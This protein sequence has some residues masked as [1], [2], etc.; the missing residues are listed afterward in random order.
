[1]T[2]LIYGM[3]ESCPTSLMPKG[4]VLHLAETGDSSDPHPGIDLSGE[5]RSRM[6]RLQWRWGSNGG[7]YPPES[8]K[9]AFNR[10]VARCGSCAANTPDNHIWVAGNEPNHSQEGLHFPQYTAKCYEAIRTSIKAQPGHGNDIIL[11]PAIAPWNIEIGV[12]WIEYFV[13]A[14]SLCDEIDGFAIHTY[15]RGPDPMSIIADTYMNPPYDHLHNGFQT[16]RDWM[17][18]IP[19]RYKNTPVYITET[20]QNEPWLNENNGWVQMAYAEINAWNQSSK[21]PIR[22]LLLY[23][24]PRFDAYFIDS[25]NGVHAD[26]LAA[27]AHQYQVGDPDPDPG[28]TMPSGNLLLNGSMEQGFRLITNEWNVPQ[29]SINVAHNWFPWKGINDVWAE[30]KPANTPSN[31]YS[32]RVYQGDGGRQAQQWFWAQKKGMGGIYQRVAGLAIGRKVRFSVQLEMWSSSQGVDK[33]N[34]GRIHVRI[35]V[36]PYGG[37][38]PE[39]RDI[40]WSQ[41]KQ[42]MWEYAPLMV[43]TTTKSDRATLWVWTLAEWPMLHND[44][45][46]DAAQLIYTESDPGPDPDPDPDPD[47]EPGNCDLS[48]LY[49]AHAAAH[50]ALQIAHTVA[51]EAFESLI[52]D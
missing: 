10:F 39:S 6:I 46:L 50:R 12:D 33:P 32:D 18:A 22:A 2:A 51:A 3:H 1:M 26:F 7:C 23:R 43:E 34:D 41:P 17:A 52:D 27:Q 20:N 47:P 31:D 35:G 25:K 49:G 48:A 37:S 38:D 14:I 36:D 11:F 24:W 15:S 21:Q 30:Y 29:S 16:Y 19:V 28:G 13:L 40:I 8:D 44:V 42:D 5:F 9:D 4:M 45:Y